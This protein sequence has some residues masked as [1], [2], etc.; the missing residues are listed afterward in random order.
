M[1]FS[2]VI[3][4]VGADV[5][6]F[7]TGDEIFGTTDT[8]GGAFAEFV[9]VPATHLVRKPNNV[10]WE[11]AASLPTAGMTALQS[12]RIG[13]PVEKG[14]RVLINGAFGG[15]GTFAVQRAKS[16]GAHVTGVCSTPNVELVKSLGVDAVVDY[17]NET[18]TRAAAAAGARFDKVIDIVGR[19][20]WHKLLNPGGSWVAVALPGRESQLQAECAP[21]QMCCVCCSPWCCCCMSST[22]S[23]VLMQEVKKADMTELAKHGGRCHTASDNRLAARRHRRGA[24]RARR[25]Q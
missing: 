22:T 6:D 20:G 4:A 18:I 17:K 12:L 9:N 1:D 23:H 19:T 11:Q 24:R 10:T 3:E 13:R 25:P 15:V 16:M 14:Q 8:A 5:S 21:C 2:G 7:S